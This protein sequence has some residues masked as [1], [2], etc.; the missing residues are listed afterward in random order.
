MSGEHE[1]LR[2]YMP[3]NEKQSVGEILYQ[4]DQY[5]KGGISRKYWDYK[6]NLLID[7]IDSQSDNHILDIGCGEGIL[8][9]KLV[10]RYP[11]KAIT[12]IDCI[13]ENIA[14]CRKNGLPASPGS[15]YALDYQDN[16]I[17]AVFLIE[18]IEHLTEPEKG[19]AEIHR[20]L[21]PGGKLIILFPNDGFFLFSRLLMLKF[22]EAFYDPGHVKQW[23]HS[24]INK[25]LSRH[26][27]SPGKN[28]SIP[29]KIWNI[30]LHGLA[31]AI[32]DYS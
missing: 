17:D 30:S 3:V 16:S 32:K 21:K 18:V 31:V 24:E 4:R 23:T 29:F 1:P 15:L 9:E 7:Q 8:L 5:Q 19:L 27:F 6:D 10:K 25:E 12:G 28:Q 14:I 20:V 22:K 2:G 13:A 11:Q 26:H